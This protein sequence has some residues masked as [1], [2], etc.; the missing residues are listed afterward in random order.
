MDTAIGGML[1]M[2][3]LMGRAI[4][5]GDTLTGVALKEAAD[6]A[7]ERSR[8]QVSFV[9]STISGSDLFVDVANTGNTSISDYKDMDFI[10][11]YV[12]PG[13]QTGTLKAE[14]LTY[15]PGNPAAREWTDLSIAPDTFQ[16]GIW[17]PGETISLEGHLSP[18]PKTGQGETNTVWVSTPNGVTTI[19]TFY[20]P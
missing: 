12:G 10:V 5:V 16:P 17:D 13:G 18:G 19:G 8:T 2:G 20:V 6:L 9:T 7:G 11:L 14:R 15:E 3:V 4:I 1:V